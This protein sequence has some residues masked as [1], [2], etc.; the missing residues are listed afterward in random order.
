MRVHGTIFIFNLL[1]PTLI[2]LFFFRSRKIQ[3][4]SFTCKVTPELLQSS[5]AK[6]Q[7]GSHVQS[8]LAQVPPPTASPPPTP[9]SGAVDTNASHSDANALSAQAVHTEIGLLCLTN[10][11]ECMVLSIP[12]LKRQINS[13][14]VRREDIK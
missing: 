7:G 10:L 9:A 11:G 1:F 8:P 5:P 4:A 14:A 13:S 3:F 2:S 6:Q 12:E